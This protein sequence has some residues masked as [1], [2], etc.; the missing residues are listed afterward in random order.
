MDPRLR[1]RVEV[2]TLHEILSE[3][4]PYQ[5]LGLRPDSAQE[6]VDPAFRA[7]SRRLH[8]DRLAAGATPEFKVQANAVFKA[9][10]DAYR[11]LRA[12]DLR[13][14]YDNDRLAGAERAAEDTRRAAEAEAAIK[15]DPSK[16][17]RQPKAESYWKRGYQCFVD[18]DF[19]AAVMQINF[20]LQFE[21]DN[22][23]F[24]EYLEKAKAEVEAKK[25][26][27]TGNSYRIR[28]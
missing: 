16:A 26:D 24:R 27:K 8:P 6:S 4:D 12:P 15:A 21:A 2:E 19:A 22:A 5:L 28:L 18:K 11:T 20:A 14:A 10:S 7:T 17:A 25:K 13:A 9:V 3:L 1:E 23:V